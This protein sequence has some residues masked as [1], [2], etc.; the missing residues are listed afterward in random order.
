MAIGLEI[1]FILWILIIVSIV[2]VIV[3]QV[4]MPYTLG[5]II[6]GLLISIFDI[7]IGLRLTP[8]LLL[9]LFLPGLL[10]EASMNV[11]TNILYRNIKSLSI[12]AVF[13]L[14]ISVM[15]TSALLHFL[16][17]V[18]WQISLL[19]ASMIAPTD[20]IAVLAIF[21]RLGVS[22]KLAVLVEGE[23]LFN[24]GTGIVMFRIVLGLVTTGAFSLLGGVLQFLTFVLGGILIGFILGYIA[25]I[26]FRNL[27]DS[28]VQLT[29]TTILAY[30]SYLIAEHLHFS[31]VIATV[32]TGLVVGG[33]GLR[34]LAPHSRLE[35]SSFWGYIGFILNSFVFLL[36]GVELHILDLVTNIFPI[37]VAFISV[38]LGRAL[39]VY[40]FSGVI[41]RVDSARF[42]TGHR[43]RIPKRWQHVIIW[44][45]LHGGLSMVLVMSLPTDAS[46]LLGQWRAFLLATIFGTVFLSLVFQGMTMAP[47]LK[48]LGLS[49]KGKRSLEYEQAVA[50]LVLHDASEKEL[51]RMR[52]SRLISRKVF[53]RYRKQTLEGKEESESKISEMLQKYPE[54]ESNQ[55]K[56]IES[57]ILV[58]QKTALV[59]AFNKGHF[60]KETLDEQLMEID[61]KLLELS[62]E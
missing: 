19:F 20:P 45:G 40:L 17:R 7:D 62:Q 26:I 12:F 52:D 15:G 39:S 46:G 25:S 61:E 42:L 16:L 5:L 9:T 58:A 33:Y 37:I 21:K 60:S 8:E 14:F 47:L 18:P 1:E 2:S 41:N 36:I 24:D 49:G 27:D 3:R 23:S 57:A 34:Y 55:I 56:D 11:D 10:F 35:I 13:G 50:Q 53:N 54:I 22:K 28:L 4:R 32:T 30:G 31:G 29:L 44:G 51:N 38:L 48:F 59:K 6:T 43:E